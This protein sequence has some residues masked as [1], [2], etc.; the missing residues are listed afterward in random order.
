MNIKSLALGPV[1]MLREAIYRHCRDHHGQR[2]KK[3]VLHPAVYADLVNHLGI[4]A[5]CSIDGEF[6]TFEGVPIV[7]DRNAAH[8]RLVTCENEV[9]WL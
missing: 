4:H 8:P 3:I 2:P 1:D 7:P 6:K 5:Y 9:E